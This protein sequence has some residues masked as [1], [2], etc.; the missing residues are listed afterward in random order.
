MFSNV[1]SFLAVNLGREFVSEE[2]IFLTLLQAVG[3]HMYAQSTEFLRVTVR[4]CVHTAWGSLTACKNNGPI[5][6]EWKV[7][8]GSTSIRR[9]NTRE[10]A[11]SGAVTP[12]T[13]AE[14][15]HSPPRRVTFL[16]FRWPAPWLFFPFRSLAVFFLFFPVLGLSGPWLFDK[17]QVD[18][19]ITASRL[20]EEV[21][22]RTRTKSPTS[23]TG[24]EK[25]SPYCYEACRRQG[26]RPLIGDV[27]VQRNVGPVHNEDNSKRQDTKRVAGGGSEHP[28]DAIG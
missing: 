15:M 9:W 16:F 12:Q 7:K 10:I 25:R 22:W 19:V 23:K 18:S 20:H 27:S 4:V 21:S 26:C 24:S 8:Q 1:I 3:K 2:C 11:G 6:W 5:Q 13:A 17:Q 14:R 28:T